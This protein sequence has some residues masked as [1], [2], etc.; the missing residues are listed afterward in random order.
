MSFYC[1]FCGEGLAN[2]Q[3]PHCGEAGHAEEAEEEDER[4]GQSFQSPLAAP[5]ASRLLDTAYLDWLDSV[6]IENKQLEEYPY[7]WDSE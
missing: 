3:T 1:P 2:A 4:D 5:P 7:D 6:A